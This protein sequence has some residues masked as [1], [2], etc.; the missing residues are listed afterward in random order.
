MVYGLEIENFYSVRDLQVIDLRV[1]ENVP[2][3]PGRF[4][5]I[6][7][8]SKDRVP[9]VVTFFGPNAS[10]KSTV[11]RALT[12]LSWF[13]QHSFL[14][15][16]APGDQ[17]PPGIGFQPCERFYSRDTADQ[18]TRLCVHFTGAVNFSESA[19]RWNDFC[20][21]AYEVS[22]R[23]EAS[24]DG[25][26]RRPR[27]VVS[28][29]VRQWPS[30]SGKSVRVFERNERGEVAASKA[31]GLGGYQKVIEKVRSNASV[32]STLVQ[33]DHKPSLLMRDLARTVLSNIL[34]QKVEPNDDIVLRTAYAPNQPLLEALNRDIE[35]IDV[36]IRAMRIVPGTQGPLAQFEHYGLSDPLPMHLE[37]H[38]TRQFIRIFPTIA[39]ALSIG[40]VAVIDEF[41][42]SIHPSILPEIIR[43]F[44]DPARNPHDAQLWATCQAASLL[45]DL[46]K[47]EVFFCEKNHAG[48]TRIYGLRDVQAVR[49]TDNFYERYLGGVYGAVPNVG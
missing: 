28:E 41:D 37:S 29:S 47:E 34:I 43:W 8:G 9:K 39:Q 6:H 32:I 3:I 11:L 48:C 31:F 21:Y 25:L 7:V 12:F 19:E 5:P 20:R 40:G 2:D 45:E 13:V 46:Q 33:F 49:R 22:F 38:G 24:S 27:T 10:G 1:A 44:H 42:Q 35:R 15:L 26:I 18:P 14:Q 4:V 30:P 36:G 16:P 17:P 23:S